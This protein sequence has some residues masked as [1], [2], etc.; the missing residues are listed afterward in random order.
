MAVALLTWR[1][2]GLV[3]ASA[4]VISIHALQNAVG[5]FLLLF[6]V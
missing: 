2:E 5:G 1:G 3:K 6:M 4:I